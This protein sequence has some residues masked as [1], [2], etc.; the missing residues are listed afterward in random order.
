MGRYAIV[1][2]GVFFIAMGMS[3]LV[4]F[5]PMWVAAGAAI[6]TGVFLVLEK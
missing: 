2:C 1:S 4:D 3:A 6:L 5:P